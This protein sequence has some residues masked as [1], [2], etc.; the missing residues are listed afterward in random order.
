MRKLDRPDNPLPGLDGDS[1]ERPNVRGRR[2]NRTE[3]EKKEKGKEI[4]GH[5]DCIPR[6]DHFED[7]TDRIRGTSW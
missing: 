7:Y 5:T 6:S 1:R 4:G 3:E 2:K